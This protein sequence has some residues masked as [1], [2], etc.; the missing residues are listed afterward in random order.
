VRYRTTPYPALS[1]GDRDWIEGIRTRY[2]PLVSRI[3][4]HFSLV[5][6]TEV[7]EALLVAQVE[8]ALPSANPRTSRRS[9]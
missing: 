1:H 2:D 4:A 7:A 6:P 3:A 9:R 8:H 5:F